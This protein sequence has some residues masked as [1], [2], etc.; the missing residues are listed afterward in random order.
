MLDQQHD[1]EA[2]HRDRQP[3]DQPGRA[4]Q[5]R[6]R[7]CARIRRYG[8]EHRAGARTGPGADL[9]WR[10]AS[11]LTM[12]RMTATSARTT[13]LLLV[14]FGGPEGPDDVL[15]FLENVTRGRGIPRE[16]L[17]EV[18][19]HYHRFGGRSPINDQNRDVPRRRC[20]RTWPAPGSTCPVYW[21]NRNWDPYLADAVGQMAADGVTR[22]ACFVTSAYSSYSELPAVPR[23]PVAA[24]G[25]RRGRAAA[26]PA[27]ALLQPPR[28]RGA[29]RRRDPR[30][31]RRAARGASA[32]AP[33]WSSSPTRSPSR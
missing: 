29:G 15:P 31:A 25:R 22:A 32:T 23:E 1:A 21:G 5:R 4:E 11:I 7:G 20:A 10:R 6:C 16:R 24:A 8:V 33:T 17:E 2:D 18:G 30:R 27:A 13:P 19:E 14:S 3:G 28:L 26:G 12:G 9:R